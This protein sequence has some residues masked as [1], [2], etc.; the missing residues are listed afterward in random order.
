MSTSTQEQVQAFQ[1]ADPIL[2]VMEATITL[3]GVPKR[4][5]ENSIGFFRTVVS[6]IPHWRNKNK[7]IVYTEV[8]L[9]NSPHNFLPCGVVVQSEIYGGDLVTI[10]LRLR[11]EDDIG[12]DRM[13]AFRMWTKELY[14]RLNDKMQGKVARVI[15]ET[16]PRFLEGDSFNENP[17]AP[18]SG[19]ELLI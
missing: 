14:S 1:S 3:Q 4:T 5:L 12:E 2:Q 18:V 15:V 13:H 11:P 10:Q 19:Y 6:C 8:L 16:T 17:R 7:E 9:N